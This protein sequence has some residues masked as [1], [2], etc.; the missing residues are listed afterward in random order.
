MDKIPATDEKP[1]S[2]GYVLR[3]T[4]KHMRKALDVSIRKTFDRVG[5]FAHDPVKSSEVFRT[6]ASLHTMRRNLD[7]FQ[8]TH[9]EDFKQA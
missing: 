5:E 9:V 2:Q 3:T 4:A 1:F 8:A 6:L 7:E